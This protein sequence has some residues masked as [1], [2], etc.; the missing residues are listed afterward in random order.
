MHGRSFAS[1]LLVFVIFT[2]FA[3]VVSAA[4]IKPARPAAPSARDA[5]LTAENYAKIE[6]GMSVAQVKEILG[7]PRSTVTSGSSHDMTMTWFLSE[8]RGHKL[9]IRFTSGVVVSKFSN[10]SVTAPPKPAIE[11]VNPKTPKQ[12]DAP[13]D[14]FDAALADL[15]ATNVMKH[16]RAIEFF[17]KTPL[18]DKRASE[19]SHLLI[20]SMSSKDMRISS[21]AEHA[22]RKWATKEDAD[23]FLKII[24]RPQR[25]KN[26]MEKHLGQVSLALDVLARLKEPA[27]VGPM[28]KLLKN[29]FN[30]SDAA[31]A[32]KR[33]GPELA[34]KELQKAANDSSADVRLAVQEILA[35]FKDGGPE[36]AR[37]LKDLNAPKWEVRIQGVQQIGKMYVH[38]RRRAEVAR[39]LEA[40]LADENGSV[41][42][43]A[44]HSL[45][46]WGAAENE[47]ALI[48]VLGHASA[49]V[50]LAAVEALHAMGTAKAVAA[51]ESLGQD[52]D[53]RV[54]GASLEA[55]AAIEA[56]KSQ[57]AGKP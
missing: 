45:A 34:E 7:P 14:K 13:Q 28:V 18:D 23:Y 57:T 38:P 47:P 49:E 27:A 25:D 20:K 53:K 37:A 52:N 40:R 5:K 4:E 51:L 22:L 33:M 35:E 46:R 29:F 55:V 39:A 44:A 32:L 8:E 3:W 21:E 56:R 9:E 24:Q 10:L 17:A 12:A 50:R 54:A 48:K 36:L 6:P 1:G 26:G 11:E 19:V 41:A 16:L 43:A 15:S 30:R 42:Q 31:E 2:G